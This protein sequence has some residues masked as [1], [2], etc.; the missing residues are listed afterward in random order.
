LEE[1]CDEMSGFVRFESMD[2]FHM[3]LVLDR[4]CCLAELNVRKCPLFCL[5]FFV[6]DLALRSF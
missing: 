3:T 4:H 6:I 2:A 1:K 5:F